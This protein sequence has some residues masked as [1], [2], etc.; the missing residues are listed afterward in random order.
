MERYYQGIFFYQPDVPT[1][2]KLSTYII[3]EDNISNIFNFV[4]KS[5]QLFNRFTPVTEC[6][7]FCQTHFSESDVVSVGLKYWI[8]AKTT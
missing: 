2:Q 7:F 6:I 8:V 3:G 4:Q 5:D 1:E